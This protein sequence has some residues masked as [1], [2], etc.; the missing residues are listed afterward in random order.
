MNKVPDVD[1]FAVSLPDLVVLDTPAQE[2]HQQHCLFITALGH[3]GLG[4]IPACQQALNA[5]LQRN[6]THDKAQ[7]LR[8]ALSVP[9]FQ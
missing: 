4:D 8:H 9:L 6:P 5:L 2:K 3:L 1:F 7:L